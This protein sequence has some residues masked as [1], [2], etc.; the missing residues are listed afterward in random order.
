MTAAVWSTP[1]SEAALNFP[2]RT[3]IQFMN[4]HHL[5]QIT[6]RPTWLT[7]K[8]G[9]RTYIDRIVKAFPSERIHLSSPVSGLSRRDGRVY[10]T[11]NGEEL[12][13]DHVILACH[14]D[15][16]LAIL[17]AEG[18]AQ[19]KAILSQ[20]EFGKSVAVLH[21]DVR[22]MPRRRKCWSAW[23]YLV[24]QSNA[25]QVSLYVLSKRLPRGLTGQQDLLDEHIAKHLRG[26]AWPGAG[27]AQSA[28]PSS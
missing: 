18:T 28:L 23:N 8:N 6:G 20:F 4:N 26:R 9:A 19:E 24:E 25:D 1:A 5:L 2:A 15:T 12:Q 14:A 13:F 21:S 16:S 11:V 7:V 27:H 22:L 3:L 17:A 10:L